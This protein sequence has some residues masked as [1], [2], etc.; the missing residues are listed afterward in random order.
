LLSNL[1][2]YAV[3]DFG[4]TAKEFIF[5][6]ARRDH[7]CVSKLRIFSLGSRILDALRNAGWPATKG[8]KSSAAI[9]MTGF[10]IRKHSA[11]IRFYELI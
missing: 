2:K 6:R 7:Q 4:S 10:K 9:Q 11:K 8:R 1:Q 5:D 3:T